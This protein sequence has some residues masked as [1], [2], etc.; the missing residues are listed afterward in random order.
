MLP[1]ISGYS[2]ILKCKIKE[3][4]SARILFQNLVNYFGHALDALVVKLD[5]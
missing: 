2:K 3:T 5:F 4:V 1:C